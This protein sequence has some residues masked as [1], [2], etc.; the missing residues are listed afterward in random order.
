MTHLKRYELADRGFVGWEFKDRYG[1]SCS[2][3]ESSLAGESAIW[4]GV[5][6]DFQGQ[7]C[8]RMHLTQEV[9]AELLPLLQRFLKKGHLGP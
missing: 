4:F 6:E 9:V 2:L 5:D 3:Q 1:S 8:T 7:K